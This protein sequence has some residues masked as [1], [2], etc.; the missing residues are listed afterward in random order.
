MTEDKMRIIPELALTFDDVLL[1]PAHSLVLPKEVK[2]NTHLTRDITLNIP[3]ISAAMDTVTEAKLAIAMARQGGMGV[4]HKNMT[5]EELEKGAQS[6]MANFVSEHLGDLG[7]R[8]SSEV[9]IGPP[10][11]GFT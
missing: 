5:V 4:I 1:L 9:L 10:S 8:V 7:S 6:R 2:L 11:S 3:L